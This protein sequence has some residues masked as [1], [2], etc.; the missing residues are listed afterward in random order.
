MMSRSSS[1]SSL[2]EQESTVSSKE[3]P[4]KSLDS[5]LSQNGKMR[6]VPSV[7]GDAVDCSDMPSLSSYRLDEMSASCASRSISGDGDMSLPSLSSFRL[8]DMSMSSSYHSHP[9]INFSEESAEGWSSFSF[10]SGNVSGETDS[11]GEDDEGE[12]A[13][14]ERRG[15]RGP[16]V[17]VRSRSPLGGAG[18]M[19]S[20]ARKPIRNQQVQPTQTIKP[21]R[22]PMKSVSL[23]MGEPPEESRVSADSTSN[24]HSAGDSSIPD[25]TP[26]ERTESLSLSS[27]K[28]P[29]KTN[30]VSGSSSATLKTGTVTTEGS[31]SSLLR[32]GDS[33]PRLPRRTSTIDDHSK[34]SH[35]GSDDISSDGDS[36]ITDGELTGSSDD[37]ITIDSDEEFSVAS[38]DESDSINEPAKPVVDEK[39]TLKVPTRLPEDSQ[40]TSATVQIEQSTSQLE[41]QGESATDQI[42]QSTA[43]TEGSKE[44][45]NTTDNAEENDQVQEPAGPNRN[46]KSPTSVRSSTSAT[47]TETEEVDE[48]EEISKNDS[49]KREEKKRG[50]LRKV[51]SSFRQLGKTTSFKNSFKMIGRS[52]SKLKSMGQKPAPRKPKPDNNSSQDEI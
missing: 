15:S 22:R 9:P 48:P 46:R 50:L 41:P 6:D 17:P 28:Q 18:K 34:H 29:P 14:R 20:N 19:N 38:D 12:F 26:V 36:N 1:D 44:E 21:M 37:D 23:P 8:D 7:G 16:S 24:L 5:H 2:D 10:T 13:T 51:S 43:Q 30:D 3:T 52:A 49:E 35:A 47:E 42:E 25:R 4:R 40:E 32:G 39:P 45:A 27:L 11:D 33:L 31:S